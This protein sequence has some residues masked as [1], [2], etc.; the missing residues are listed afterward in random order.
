MSVAADTLMV[1]SAGSAE[2]MALRVTDHYERRG[3]VLWGLARRLGATEEQSADVVQ[4]AHLRLWRALTTGTHIEDL[5]AWTF[6]VTYRLIMDQHRLGRRARDL[7]ERLMDP[8]AMVVTPVP[9]EAL[10]LWPMVDRL[11]GRERTTLYLHYR[12]DLSFVQVGHVMG[13]TAASARTYASRGM[14]R[15]RALIDET[16][17]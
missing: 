5:D 16:E 3:R 4:E 14:E 1:T 10:S 6:R 12:A 9:D 8:K 17:R 13:I 15:L 7:L 11:P 2:A